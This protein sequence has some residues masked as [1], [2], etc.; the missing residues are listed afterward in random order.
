MAV[1]SSV[2]TASALGRKRTVTV[3]GPGAASASVQSP[4]W[5][6]PVAP[7][8]PTTAATVPG[9]VGTTGNARPTTTR[10]GTSTRGGVA[11]GRPAGHGP[12]AVMPAP[13]GATTS[14]RPRVSHLSPAFA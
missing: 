13:T 1:A 12:G 8:G 11:G 5:A 10:A 6:V 7:P 9:T 2:Q 4:S 14:A 3:A